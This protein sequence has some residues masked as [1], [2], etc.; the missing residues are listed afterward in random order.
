MAGSPEPIVPLNPN[1]EYL[2]MTPETY[3]KERLIPHQVWYNNKY[4]RKKN[5]HH[6]LRVTVIIGG[7]LVA[8]LGTSALAGKDIVISVLGLLVSVAGSMESIFQFRENWKVY[9]S[10]ALNMDHEKTRFQ[11]RSGEYAGL[12]D[13]DAFRL[14]VEKIESYNNQS[15]KDLVNLLTQGPKS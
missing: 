10:I 11:T 8:W 12:T 3:I 5:W 14:L 7:L 4:I 9:N 6:V 2:S 1:A 15:S 13:A